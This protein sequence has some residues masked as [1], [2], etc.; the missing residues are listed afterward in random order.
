MSCDFAIWYPH[1]RLNDKEATNL[2][3]ALCDGV[4]G[5]VA[6][7]PAI[8]AFYRELTAL[9]PEIDDIPEE[10]IDDLDYCPWSVAFDRSPGHLI[11]CCVWPKADYVERLV[12]Q[13]AHKHGLAVYDPQAGK[14]TYPDGPAERG[15]MERQRRRWKFW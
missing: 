11:M 7:H 2:Y 14:I 15:K 1:R 12:K 9:H 13:L 4:V 6:P 3:H 8:D 5:G 10:R